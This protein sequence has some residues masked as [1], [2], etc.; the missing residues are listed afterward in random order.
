MTDK[1][2]RRSGCWSITSFDP[3]EH[4]KL[5]GELPDFVRE[6]HGGLE[7]CPNTKRIH[8]QGAL[9]TKHCRFSQVKRWLPSAHIEAAIKKEALIAYAMK[10]DTSI[11]E[12]KKI[13]NDRPYFSMEK[14]LE[15]LGK[16]FFYCRL[17]DDKEDFV[18]KG[19]HLE[20]DDEVIGLDKNYWKVVNTILYARPYL[21]SV[22][23]NPQTLRSW[24]NTYAVWMFHAKR[25][26]ESREAWFESETQLNPFLV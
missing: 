9:I 17:E 16:Y 4:N 26:S 23:S 3:E 11:G 14:S 5:N 21:V 24:R 1:T 6:V 8:Y 20:D 12:K 22:Y 15:L 2:D 13:V 7:E 19:K 18:G 25:H 10:E